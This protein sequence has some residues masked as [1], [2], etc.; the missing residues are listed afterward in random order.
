MI[1][2]L[3][4]PRSQGLFP[5]L[6][7]RRPPSSQGK[8]PGNEVEANHSIYSTFTA[9]LIDGGGFGW[10]HNAGTSLVD[11]GVYLRLRPLFGP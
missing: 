6:R 5:S 9:W 4:Q 11:L 1:E 7:A 8:G 10:A 2:R 3:T